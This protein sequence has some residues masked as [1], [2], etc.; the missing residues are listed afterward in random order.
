MTRALMILP[1]FIES[2]KIPVLLKEHFI[3]GQ[4]TFK[5]KALCPENG[6]ASAEL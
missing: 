4:I 2:V 3:F 1:T 5:Q 6:K